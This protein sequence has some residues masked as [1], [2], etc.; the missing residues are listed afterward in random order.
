[1]DGGR[2]GGREK[3]KRAP[4]WGGRKR[5]TSQDKHGAQR[6]RRYLESLHQHKISSASFPHQVTYLSGKESFGP[7]LAQGR[8]A[9]GPRTV[10]CTDGLLSCGQDLIQFVCGEV[11]RSERQ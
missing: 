1:M 5:G 10:A 7:V 9:T 6:C 11:K 8:K 2:E 4:D 3:R